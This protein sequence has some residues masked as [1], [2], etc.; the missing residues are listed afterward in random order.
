MTTNI[1]PDM[2]EEQYHAVP[3]LSASGAWLLAQEC[4]AIYWHGSP[5][6]PDAA[7]EETNGAM[8]IG[9]ALHLAML[10]PA[11]LA[12][13]IAVVDAEDWRT[14]AAKE[15]R[16]RARDAGLT[17]LLMKDRNLVSELAAALR[18]NRYVDDLLD[19]ARTEL[20]YFWTADNGVP[21][22]ARA[23]LVTRDGS[24]IA[25][26]KASVSAA[27]DFF[28]RRAFAAGHF[29][30]APWYLDGAAAAGLGVVRDY[31]FVVV[32]RKPP[33]LVTLCRLDERA[34]AWGHQMIRRS[35]ELFQRCR[36]AGLWPGYSPEPTTLGLP[37]WAEY[38]LADREAVGDFSPEAADALIRAGM[39]LYAP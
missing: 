36:A 28:R 16:D 14:K 32:A 33:H 17:P 21:C 9:T 3:A 38:G 13:R 8:D 10:E 24:A 29:L 6:N 39:E 18:G 31:W 27:P 1:V 23:D 30:R 2:P 20:S 22:K 37:T 25:D 4:P 11:R 15:A 7:P 35:L 19:G 5:F 34:L 26:F 12:D